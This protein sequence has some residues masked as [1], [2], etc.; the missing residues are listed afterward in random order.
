MTRFT[1]RTKST[2]YYLPNA[3]LFEI[4]WFGQSITGGISADIISNMPKQGAVCLCEIQVSA[5]NRNS[6][7]FELVKCEAE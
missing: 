7:V 5:D 1:G 4:E 6:L 3:R 2:I